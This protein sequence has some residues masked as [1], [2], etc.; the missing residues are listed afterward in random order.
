M[1]LRR[2]LLVA[3]LAA[4]CAQVTAQVRVWES[5]LTLPTYEEGPPDQ[6][7]PF[8][9]FSTTQF[10]YPYTL[11]ENL[12]NRRVNHAW[13]A[14]FLE[15]EYLQCSILPDL[16]G[17]LYTCIDKIGGQ[18]MFYA[19]PSIKKARVGY[20]G[21]WAAFGIEFNFPVSHNWVSMS[22][23]AYD[24]SRNLDG[25]ASVRVGNIDRVYGMEWTVELVLRPG[26]TVL[27]ERVT[28]NNRSDTRHRFY[29]W[30]NAAIEV[31][32][33]SRIAYPMRFTASHGFK[34]VDT[35]PVDSS[36]A[37]LSVIRNQTKGPVSLFA[38]GSRE[39][40]M[41]VWRPDTGTG[42]VHYADYGSLPAKK[43]WSWG[44]D[45]DGLD[46][47]NALSDNN[48][49]YVEVQ[50][51]LFRN[52]ETYAF[53]EPRQTIHFSEYWMP[54]RGIGGI[55]RANLAGVLN[56]SR[57][58]T[59]LTV[60]FNANQAYPGAVIRILDG[61]RL[62]AEEKADLQPQRPWSK[63][64][65]PAGA[66]AYSF[67]A[68][69]AGGRLLLQHT[70][71][72]YDWTPASEIRT[73]PQ[74]AYRIPPPAKRTEDDWVEQGKEEELNGKLLVAMVT[75][76]NGLTSFPQS[77][78]LEKAAGRLAVSLLRYADAVRYLESAAARATQDPEVAYY[79]GLAYEELGRNRDAQ[80]MY[81]SAALLPA[82]R[83]AAH[84]R[85]AE[86]LARTG[87]GNEA[88]ALLRSIPDDLRA[89]E[90]TVALDN[91]MGRPDE[92]RVLSR[93]EAPAL[94]PFLEFEQAQQPSQD[95][96]LMRFLAADPDRV[97]DIAAE[98]MRLG[99]YRRALEVLSLQYPAVP[100]D[101]TEPGA[102]LPQ[103]HPIVARYRAYCREKLNESPNADDALAE[104]M[105]LAYIFPSGATTLDVLQSALQ[106]DSQDATAHYLL[107]TLYLSYGQT[108]PAISSWEKAGRLNPRLPTLHADLGRALLHIRNDPARAREVFQ[109]GMSADPENP[110]IYIGMDQT[111][112]LLGRSAR[113]RV[114]ALQRYPDSAGMPAELVYKLA[115][116]RAESG[117]YDGALALFPGRFFPRQEGGTN[118]RQVWLEVRILQ[119]LDFAR[120]GHCDAF[121]S[122][123]RDLGKGVAGLDFTQD[124]MDPLIQSARVQYLLG[125]GE[126][127]CGRPGEAAAHFRTAAD[128]I[129]PAEIVW[130]RR[131]AHRLPGY[132]DSTWQPRLEAALARIEGE[133]ETR[134]LKGIWIYA[135]GMIERELG[136]QEAA[137]ERFRQASLLADRMLSLH[138]SRLAIAENAK[139]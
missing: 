3:I 137:M 101:Q 35:W 136:R 131:A 99:L 24:Y 91:A 1:R 87:R 88:L 64:I 45:A 75:Y 16:G 81:E 27:E 42:A 122:S 51:G 9:Q 100:A 22:P 90:E 110:E 108:D 48:S 52:Q 97:L 8:D 114:E 6:N 37:D 39:T 116:N 12:T 54:V 4:A 111:L 89:V 26:S 68:R 126:S 73:G 59:A 43:I 71:N 34:E 47:R 13:R 94:S 82:F 83:E 11:R 127:Q 77:F 103:R 93:G 44:V 18:P 19:N 98:Y 49:A 123:A 23:V 105:P 30:N 113:E 78:A 61:S 112:S 20:R 74:P 80:T 17:H 104:K 70:E 28:L 60:A 132:D 118:V 138:L 66:G 79:L 128:S 21:A 46:W 135:A 67:E 119:L 31:K 33:D 15:N 2:F 120:A 130:A 85:L 139:P 107:G 134:S 96:R 36:G 109:E 57:T 102:V 40:F 5:V 76:E 25:S 106:R 124:G 62:V 58:G 92:A 86:L 84:L 50:A 14:V 55:A 56:L 133:I 95:E 129:S 29:W 38:H 53:L 65:D 121:H 63:K 125:T 10:S 117:D 41:G 32:D 69:D 115:L 72:K 7:P